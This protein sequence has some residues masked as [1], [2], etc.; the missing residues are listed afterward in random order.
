M[1]ADTKIEEEI[2]KVSL[3]WISYY[4]SALIHAFSKNK[5]S[6]KDKFFYIF[7]TEDPDLHNSD[8]LYP[9]PKSGIRSIISDKISQARVILDVNGDI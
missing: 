7:D 6:K 5:S 2:K 8:K 4:F 1:D 9:D 3:V